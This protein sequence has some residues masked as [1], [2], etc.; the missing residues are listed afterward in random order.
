[1]LCW[2]VKQNN[3]FVI[4]NKILR[5]AVTVPDTLPSRTAHPV[6]AFFLYM[7]LLPYNKPSLSISDHISLLEQRGLIIADHALATN[8][9]KNVGYYRLAGYWRIFQNDPVAHTFKADTTFEHIIELYNFDRELRLLLLDAIE[10]IEVSFRAHII[11]EMCAAH[12]ANWFAYETLAFDTD[13]LD[14]ILLAVDKEL[15]RTD[16]D[17]V[18]H[19]KRKYGAEEYPPAWKTLQVL[20]LG[21]LS[22]LYGNIKNNIPE[23]KAIA[24]S[25]GLASGDFLHSWMHALSVLRN[26][27][28]HH[29][30]VC[31]RTFSFPPKLMHRPR[32][33]WISIEKLP[34]ATGPLIQLLFLQ[35]SAVRYLLH[36]ASPGN[37][38][39]EKL[40][41]LI[42][43]YPSIE[44]NRMGFPPDWQ[45]EPLW[46]ESRR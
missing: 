9:L 20:S 41:F 29:S 18:A 13:A 7:E 36:T 2:K 24:T 4:A 44:L 40:K 31:Y 15:G 21:T 27:C 22:Q 16:E 1:M 35:I 39:T 5:F 38:F 10:R 14:K 42:Q 46:I 37:H 6:G 25:F 8:F 28:A 3:Y 43:K 19:H 12:P 30:R 32:L 11:N 26:L 33:A 23:K 34:Q 45:E 17:F